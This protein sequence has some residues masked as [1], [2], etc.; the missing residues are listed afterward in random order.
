DWQL[1]NPFTDKCM[2]NDFLAYE[3]FEQM[4]HYSCRRRFVEV[5]VH[6]GGGKL[7]AADYHGIEVLLEKIEIDRNRVDLK[8]LTPAITSEPEI[9]GGYIFKKDKSSN[10]DLDFS[11]MGGGGFPAQQLKLHEPK[12]REVGNN[13]N[14]PQV[15]WLR[16]YLNTMESKLYASS[17]LTATGTNHYSYYLDT[18]GFVDQFWIVE[19]PKAIDGYRLSDFFSKDRNG[20]IKPEPIWDWKLSFG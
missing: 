11:T 4:G 6:Q 20:K 12:P 3:L 13:V 14:H 8:R 16:N 2:M 19:F 9:S 7:S 1:R 10:D 18:D 15:V 17:W 5:F